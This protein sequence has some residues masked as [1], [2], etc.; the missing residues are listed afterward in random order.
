MITTLPH[1]RYELPLSTTSTA[2]AYV[3]AVDRLLS[4]N[5]GATVGFARAVELDEGFALGHAGQALNWALLRQP[6]R[7]KPAIERAQALAGGLLPR[8]RRHIAAVAA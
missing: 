3:D 4:V 8:E 7:A 1:D 6:A 2:A 5:P